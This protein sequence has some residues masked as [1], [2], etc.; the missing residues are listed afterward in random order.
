M[1]MGHGFRPELHVFCKIIGSFAL[2]HSYMQNLRLFT[3]PG[4]L[5]A[6]GISKTSWDESSGECLQGLANNSILFSLYFFEKKNQNK[7]PSFLL[8]G[9]L[10]AFWHGHK[11]VSNTAFL[12][13]K[14]WNFA[15]WLH[16]KYHINLCCFPRTHLRRNRG[17]YAINHIKTAKNDFLVVN[18]CVLCHEDVQQI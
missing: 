3:D 11:S 2:D 18:W 9:L 16:G 5:P 4:S 8:T 6:Y 17:F 13:Q 14:Q 1:L 10:K 7:I 12:M 15:G